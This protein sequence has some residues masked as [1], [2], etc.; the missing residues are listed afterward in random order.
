LILRTKLR[1]EDVHLGRAGRPADRPLHTDHAYGRSAGRLADMQELLKKKYLLFSLHAIEYQALH[2]V[3][4]PSGSKVMSKK[5][6]I[7]VRIEL[8]LKIVVLFIF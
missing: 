8:L 6:C 5:L 1:I 7:M 2:Y 3:A 4:S